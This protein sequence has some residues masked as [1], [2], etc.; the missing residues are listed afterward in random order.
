MPRLRAAN[1]I[2][3]PFPATL[4][5]AVVWAEAEQPHNCYLLKSIAE[6]CGSIAKKVKNQSRLNDFS[7]TVTR[8]V[9]QQLETLS[10]HSRW[11]AE[12]VFDH[13]HEVKTSKPLSADKR[14]FSKNCSAWEGNYEQSRFVSAHEE[15]QVANMDGI[16]VLKFYKRVQKCL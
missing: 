12:E 14:D 7:L 1:E 3:P 9:S 5:L 2:P 8:T 13:R 4:L 10:F 11:K 16:A 6:K 15:N